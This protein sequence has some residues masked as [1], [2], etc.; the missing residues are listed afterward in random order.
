MPTHLKIIKFAEFALD[1]PKRTLV[2]GDELVSL[3]N[4]EFDT[5]LFLVEH[6]GEILSKDRIME[7]IW[8]DTIVDENSI[9]KVIAGI[10]KALHD[11]AFQPKFVKTVSKKGYVFIHEA[12]EISPVERTNGS[13][14]PQKVNLPS[15][16]D[17]RA[18]KKRSQILKAFLISLF[19]IATIG[20]LS[21]YSFYNSPSD[22]DQIRRVVQE[23]QMYESLVLYKNPSNF[24]EADLD[25]YWAKEIDGDA[26]YDRQHI[27]N[28]VHKLIDRGEKYGNETKAEKFEFQSIEIN[29]KADFAIVKTLE[30]WF[31]TVY[32]NGGSLI[33]NK[34]VGPYFV[35]YAVRKID[36]NWLVEKSSTA[37]ASQLPP[38]LSSIV[39]TSGVTAGKQFFVKFTG[40]KFNPDTIFVKVIG[41]NC[42]E[43]NPC[44]VPNSALRLDSELTESSLNDVPLTLTTGNF[45]LSVQNGESRPSNSL[46]ITVP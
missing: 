1:A 15:I 23:S 12:D 17:P 26:S 4:R 44:V 35:S 27:R 6:R 41:P 16:S 36:G 33:N 29:E 3:E 37:R 19:V 20:S 40:N 18:N 28:G 46:T 13:R 31:I 38:E 2:H 32:D 43:S 7:E 39:P 42:P 34:T 14:A 21:F 25:K 22:E 11:S 10:R 45:I 9:E 8:G 5:L 30:Q 24:Q